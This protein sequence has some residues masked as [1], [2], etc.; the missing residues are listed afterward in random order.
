MT[1]LLF[2]SQSAAKLLILKGPQG[3]MR[4]SLSLENEM[5]GLHHD[6]F[7]LRLQQRRD[8]KWNL[9]HSPLIGWW[10]EGRTGQARVSPETDNAILLVL[11][12]WD[13]VVHTYLVY[14]N[15]TC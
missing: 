4:G 9:Q 12:Y 14:E 7:L 6:S 8:K 13:S 5:P 10:H 15:M 11:K 1:K 3:S 2:C